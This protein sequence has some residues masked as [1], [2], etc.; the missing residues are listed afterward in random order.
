MIKN[1]TNL[2]LEVV[3]DNGNVDHSDRRSGPF[4]L[5]H[6]HYVRRIEGG[7]GRRE[8]QDRRH[9]L[10][11]G[12]HLVP[13]CGRTL[14]DPCDRTGCASDCRQAVVSYSK[15][16]APHVHFGGTVLC[17]RPLRRKRFPRHE[18]RGGHFGRRAQQP[19]RAGAGNPRHAHPAGHRHQR[20]AADDERVLD[21]VHPPLEQEAESRAGQPHHEHDPGQRGAAKAHCLL[22]SVHRERRVRVPAREAGIAHAL[23]RMEQ[24]GAIQIISQFPKLT[25]GQGLGGVHPNHQAYSAR[26]E[27]KAPP[28][29]VIK[30]PI[31][32]LDIEP[33]RDGAVRPSLEFFT[34]EMATYVR[35]GRK[36]VLT[37]ITMESMGMLLEVW[38]TLNVQC[39]VY[40][41]DSFTFDDFVD[42]MRYH[43]SD[44]TCDLLEEMYCA[45]LKLLV[46]DKGKLALPKNTL[47][48]MVEESEESSDEQ[49]D[50]SEMST[51]L[52]DVPARSTR[53]R[54]SHVDPSQEYPRSPTNPETPHSAKEMLGERDW[55]T[56]LAARDFENGGW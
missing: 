33:K 45:V 39:E 22:Q 29:P 37:D 17:Q 32:D 36:N 41:L 1:C 15:Q 30:Y 46:D 28:P 25:S 7:R 12:G 3:Y 24:V 4:H 19:R 9:L 51:P 26:N 20:V 18:A 40:V 43:S 52:P 8:W 16:R 14:D 35:E 13:A 34:D 2:N 54:L 44:P 27:P 48:E 53:S 42:A 11:M 47:P 50:E 23:T 56:R 49:Q 21:R 55:V 5:R 31:E 10:R 6:D 38:N